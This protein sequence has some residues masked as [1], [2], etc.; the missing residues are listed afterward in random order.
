MGTPDSI[1]AA[2]APTPATIAADLAGL[3]GADKVSLAADVLAS[4]AA[5]KWSATHLPDLVVFAESSGDVAAVLA[6]AHARRVAVTPRGAGIGYVGGCVPIQGGIVLSTARMNRILGI[7]PDDG[8][9]VVQPGVIT[10]A[11]Q[12]AARAVGW[13]YPPD[14]ASLKECSI[15]GNIATN[16]GGPRCLKYGVTR[17]YVL[18][19][20]VV[21][22]DGRI[23]R[24]GGRT[25][26]NKTGFDLIGLFTGSEGMLGVV[27]EATLRLIPRPA[28]RGMFAAVFPDFALAAAA[29]QAIL[30]AG[31]LPSAL[32]I[33][34][35]FTLA[36]ARRRLGPQ[37]FPPGDA[38]LMVEI[39]GRPAAVLAELDEL[40]PL[41]AALGATSIDRAPDE[42]SCERIWQLRREFSYALRDTG[43]MKL[44][45]D[46][47]VPRSQL[48]ELVAFAKKLE[49]DTGIPIACFGHAGDGNIHTNLMVG[50]YADP[51]VREAA[52]RALDE[53][54][55]WVLAHGGA[56]TGE[57]GVGLA[58][59][60][61]IKSALGDVS[62]DVHHA[63]KR[64][65][66]PH[67]ILNPG[68]FLDTAEA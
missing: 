32:E 9:A 39:D 12:E 2:A 15:G 6:Y 27:T 41:L 11:L 17:A 43:L 14:P 38:Y 20:E 16:A 58:K 66:D 64:A 45:E 3:I 34:D 57:H 48:V 65:L 23:L 18:G 55:G 40:H 47:V 63:I 31:H 59:K 30:N 53:L 10:L 54:F 5:D 13:E 51:V 35:G 4:H 37:V 26:K 49:S 67:H 62:L 68:K 24:S 25:H 29:V 33:T 1:A 60:P 52:H 36:A 19:L 46:I 28:S 44:N 50:N 21:L 56:I 7:H 42:A 8:V 22:A 61:W